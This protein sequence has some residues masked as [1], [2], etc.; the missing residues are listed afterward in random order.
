MRSAAFRERYADLLRVAY[1]A[2]D[3]GGPPDVVLAR[4]R[5]AV[6]AVRP[7]VPYPRLRARL[8]AVLLASP[9]RP[10]LRPHRLLFRPDPLPPGPARLALRALSPHERLVYVLHRVEGLTSPE[11]A[12]EVSEHLMVSAWDV[13]RTAAAMDLATRLDA[14]AQRAELRAFDPMLVR[15]RPPPR[16]PRFWAAVLLVPVVAGA[17]VARPWARDGG[18]VPLLVGDADWQRAATPTLAH[19]P[20]R[21]GSRGD[22][23]L[24]SRAATAW[25]AHRRDPPSGPI[26]VLYAGAVDDATVVV[27]RDSP[28]HRDTPMVAQY[29]E[30][31]LSRGVESVRRLDSDFGGL[32]MLGGT[33]RYLLPPWLM[34]PYLAVP[35]AAPRWRPLAVRDGLTDPVEWRW[36]TPRCQNYLLFRMT[37]RPVAGGWPRR[38]LQFASHNPDAAAPRVWFRGAAARDERFQN[39]ASHAVACQGA[40]SLSDS[41]DLRVGRLWTGDLPDGGGPASLTVV[42]TESPWNAPGA[43]VLLSPAGRVLTQRGGTNSDYSTGE[44][45]MAAAVWWLAKERWHLVAA[46]GPGVTTLRTAG[47][48]GDH[49]ARGPRPFLH[50]RG[51]AR[52]TPP[53]PATYLPLVWVVAEEPAGTRTTITPS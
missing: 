34:D 12:A 10:R 51:P 38:V 21:G 26:V 32:I 7:G 48:L 50:V 1:L 5:R 23:A 24:L 36:F 27:L 19:W 41:G 11:A 14:A 29:F 43:A 9:P 25:R 3:D 17:L 39:A 16:P 40:A 2:L 52:R 44:S 6:R 31:R 20:T 46:A 45:G 15:L 35:A 42:D 13:D 8:A 49:Q 47:E 30:R 33:W 37:H 22:R 18:D 28:G 4:A 53:L